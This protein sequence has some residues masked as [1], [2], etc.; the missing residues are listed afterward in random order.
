MRILI[1]YNKLDI[2]NNSSNVSL[3]PL[4]VAPAI[5]NTMYIKLGGGISNWN[6]KD[7]FLGKNQIKSRTIKELNPNT[8]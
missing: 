7:L 5:I 1:L 2:A 8:G 6:K 4:K 3:W